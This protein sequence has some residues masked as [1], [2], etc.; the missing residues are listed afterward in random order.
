MTVKK[1]KQV[2]TLNTSEFRTSMVLQL[3]TLKENR[4]YMFS[5]DFSL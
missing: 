1:S 3:C 2:A 4:P 5:V